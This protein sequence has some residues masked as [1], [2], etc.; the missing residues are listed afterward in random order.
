MHEW[1]YHKLLATDNDV[2]L[3]CI[4][5]TRRVSSLAYCTSTVQCHGNAIVSAP[6][7]NFIKLHEHLHTRT[8]TQPRDR[9]RLR[10]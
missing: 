3:K 7:D 1:N 2:D 4:K 5:L 10:G 9:L 6:T 8:A